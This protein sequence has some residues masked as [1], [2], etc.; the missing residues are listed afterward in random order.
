MARTMKDSGIEWIGQIPN[1][2]DTDRLQWHLEEINVSNNPIQTDKILSLTIETGVIPYE[3][4]GNQGNKSKENLEEYKLAYPDTLVVNSMNIIIGAVGISR[5]FG[6]VSPVYYVFNVT[7]DSDLRYIYYLFTNVGF[8]KE[9]RKYAKGILEIRLRI[10]AS[11]MLKL[12]IPKLSLKEQ[13]TIASFLDS[14]CASIDA[15]IEK[16]K[17]SI[18]EYKKLKQA[19]ITK[20]VTKGIRPN[21]KMRNSG[22]ECIGQI[23]EE[24]DVIKLKRLSTAIGDGIHS[25]PE[26]DDNGE[27]FFVNGNN[28]GEEF[29]EIKKDTNRLSSDERKKYPVEKINSQTIMIALNGATYGKTSL[30]RELPIL[31]GKSA[32][33]ITLKSDVDRKFVRYYFLSNPAKIMMALSLNGT[34]I[35]NLSLTTLNNFWVPFPNEDEQKQIADYLD[36][37]CRNLDL[38]IKKKVEVLESQSSLKKSLIYEYVTGKKE[39]LA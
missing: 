12:K 34:T 2:W 9:M 23:P 4:K 3:D 28:I 18:E 33:Y 6:C 24:W 8:Q 30:Y 5:Y 32:G 17:A 10:S 26:Y 11:D 16:T 22:I 14:K 37:K 29:I 13:Q 21:R 1:D 31:L 7:K 36:E 19:I 35:Q 25:S 39:V 27:Y 38:I 20:A 15:V